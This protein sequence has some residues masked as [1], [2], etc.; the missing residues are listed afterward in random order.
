MVDD[1][2]PENVPEASGTPAMNGGL[3]EGQEFGP[4]LVDPRVANGSA[5]DQKPRVCTIISLQEA[6]RSLY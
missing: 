4:H 3:L 1:P 6:K 5:N 2:A